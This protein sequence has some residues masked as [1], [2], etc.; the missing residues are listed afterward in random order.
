MKYRSFKALQPKIA[1]SVLSLEEG[2]ALLIET[3]FRTRIQDFQQEWFV[4]QEWSSS[5]LGM[6]K[7]E[8]SRELINNKMVEFEENAERARLNKEREK[9]IESNRKVS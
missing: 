2:R 5:S 4:P 3:G 8:W 1:R 6:K 9:N 7:I